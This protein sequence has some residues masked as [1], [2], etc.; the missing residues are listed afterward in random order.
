MGLLNR[1]E[2]WLNTKLGQAA[3]V[4]ITYS[5]GA[6]SVS[7]TADSGYCWVGRTGFSSNRVGGARFEWGDRDYMILP[8]AIAAKFGEPQDGD[9]ITETVNGVVC[10]F[11]VLRPD[12][13]EPAWRWSDPARTRMRLHVKQVA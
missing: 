7:I 2:S 8:A 1:A 12:T 6:E 4:A 3:G 5:R 11:D 9:R 10:V 13:G